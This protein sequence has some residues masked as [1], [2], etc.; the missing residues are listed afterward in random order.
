MILRF[1]IDH[2]TGH[3][4]E[5]FS[6]RQLMWFV[7]IFVPLRRRLSCVRCREPSIDRHVERDDNQ[8]MSEDAR[9]YAP[10]AARNR[11]P[12]LQVLQRHLPSRGLVLEVAS[13]SGEHVVHFAKAS[14][15]DLIFQPSDPEPGARV[16]IDA[17]ATTLGLRNVRAAIALDAASDCWPI[18]RADVVLCINMIHIAPWAACFTFAVLSAGTAATRRR[19]T[20]LSTGTSERAIPPGACAISKRLSRWPKPMVSRGRWSR[21]CPPTTFLWCSGGG[22]RWTAGRHW[23]ARDVLGSA[24]AKGSRRRPRRARQLSSRPASGTLHNCRTWGVS[25]RP[26]QSHNY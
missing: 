19:A 21:R 6:I 4:G 10:A 2:C 11:E 17:W 8:S 3:S 24:V 22:R 15:P 14:G 20:R 7:S 26:M 18:A 13:G 25:R 1:S 5:A 12:I 16:S 9:L 23:A